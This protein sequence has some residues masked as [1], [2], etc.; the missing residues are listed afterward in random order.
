M[1]KKLIFLTLSCMVFLFVSC[2][3]PLGNDVSGNGEPGQDEPEEYSLSLEGIPVYWRDSAALV[4]DDGPV[5]LSFWEKDADGVPISSGWGSLRV[6]KYEQKAGEI[7]KGTLALSLPEEIPD[8][9]L[10]ES[11]Y[12]IFGESM[13]RLSGYTGEGTPG[14]LVGVAGFD[15]LAKRTDGR[16]LADV[17]YPSFVYATEDGRIGCQSGGYVALKRGWNFLIFTDYTKGEY[18]WYRSLQKLYDCYPFEFQTSYYAFDDNPP[19]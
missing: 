9:F 10:L 14:L 16:R 13:M 6:V 18:V 17:L 11:R 3:D 12:N 4:E 15:N 8:D 1:K 5:Y 7:K 2:G 19:Q